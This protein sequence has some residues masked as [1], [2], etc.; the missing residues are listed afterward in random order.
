[1]DRKKEN[2]ISFYIRMV[3]D[4]YTEPLYQRH[5]LDVSRGMLLGV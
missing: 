4:K 1:M 3:K 5:G 2:C